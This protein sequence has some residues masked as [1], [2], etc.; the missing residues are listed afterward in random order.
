MRKLLKV[1]LLF[2]LASCSSLKIYKPD[3]AIKNPA[4]VNI[5]ATKSK[6]RVFVKE[7]VQLSLANISK[8]TPEE[9]KKIRR[10]DRNI[11]GPACKLE[12]I[13]TIK[14]KAKEMIKDVPVPTDRVLNFYFKYIM[15]HG[16]STYIN[17]GNFIFQPKPAHRYTFFYDDSE[18]GFLEFKVIDNFNNKQSELSLKTHE[19]INCEG[20][21]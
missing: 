6:N 11:A 1:L 12:D 21:K 8:R 4:Y 14:G 17:F 19:T 13:G 18:K 20:K 2:L 9:M 16:N 3:K 7:T 15:T 5:D 10:K